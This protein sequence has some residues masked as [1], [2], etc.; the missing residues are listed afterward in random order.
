MFN[1]HPL[2]DTCVVDIPNIVKEAPQVSIVVP[3]YNEEKSFNGLIERITAILDSFH[4]T[5]QVVLVND[6]SK[7]NTPYLMQLLSEEDKRFKSVFL[8]RNHGHQIAVSAGMLH[9][10]AEEAIMI[11][12]GDLQDP[13]ELIEEFYKKLKEGYDVIYAIRKNRKEG[14][15]LKFAFWSYY[16][17][18]RMISNYDIPIDSGD[19]CMISKRVRDIIV[20][21]PEESRYLRGMRSW[22]GFKQYGYE[23]DRGERHAG[24]SNYSLKKRVEFA[25]NGIFNFSKYPIHIMFR[26]GFFSISI[27][28]IYT[29]YLLYLKFTSD[30]LSPGFLTIIFAISFFSGVQLISLGLIGEYVFRTYSQVRQRPLF[31]IDKVIN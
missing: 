18:Q 27:S 23:Y 5:I 24:D 12:D 20:S 28:V 16:R 11:I 25:L 21:M 14:M 31:I 10:D 2:A 4:L 1:S 30:A 8:S 7:D 26:L 9:A 17:I 19:F 6:G 13:P 22:V 29:L 3:L 15:M